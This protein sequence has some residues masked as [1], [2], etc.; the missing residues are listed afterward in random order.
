MATSMP[1]PVEFRLPAGW[2]P[3]PP[4]E[5]GAPGAAFVA[6]HPATNRPGF[7]T[8][9]TVDGEQRS[10]D[11]SL[12]TIA[13]ESV[14][15]LHQVSR[16]V[17]LSQRS[18]FGSVEAPGLT[19]VLKVSAP[20]GENTL[21][22]VQCQVYLSMPDVDDPGRRAVVRLVLTATADVFDSVVAGFQEFVASVRPKNRAD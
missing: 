6:L 1:V 4:E 7:T 22:L 19:Q 8:N 16:T 5:V 12:A 18:E 11:A 15:N 2:Q 10:D 20:S 14:N 13:D 17:S 3:A 9:I 21:D